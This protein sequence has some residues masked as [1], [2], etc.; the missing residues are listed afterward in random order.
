MLPET[1]AIIPARGGSKRIPRKN[2]KAF[3][4]KPILGHVIEILKDSQAF[5]EILVS[6]DDTEIKM[7]A[8][9]FGA[10][11]VIDRPEFLA[12]DLTPTQ[13]VIQHAIQERGLHDSLICCVYPCN[14]LLTKATIT[15]CLDQVRKSPDRFSFPVLEYRH[16]IQ[17]AF[18]MSGDGQLTF[19]TPEHELS[20]TQDLTKPLH[21]AGSIYCALASVWLSD[22]RIHSNANG[23]LV[24][25][26]EAIDIDHEQDWTLA[27]KIFSTRS[28]SDD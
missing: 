3:L 1:V 4:G 23:I 26:T 22:M 17:R 9:D 20:R 7:I 2:I 11:S 28:L 14:P 18:T 25:H 6:T 8:S 16:P 12:D 24:D 10:D 13:P 15:A 5:G 21:D 27:E 19:R